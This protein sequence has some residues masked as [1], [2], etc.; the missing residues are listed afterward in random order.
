[1]E[2]VTVKGNK[3]VDGANREV[4]LQGI[5]FVCKEKNKGYLWPEH[6]R[7]FAWCAWMGFN[8]IRLGIFWDGVEPEPGKYD[9]AY[10]EKIKGVI[11]DAQEQGLYV[12]VDM[13]QD[14]WSVLYA[15][16][17]PEWA[18]LTD[19]A[20]H[21]TDCAIWF[22]A[23]LRSDAIINAADH[24]WKNDPAADGR[25]LMDHYEAMW[26][27]IAQTLGGCP[28]VIG[29]EPMNEPFMG[30]IARG[31]FGAAAMET[32]QKYP[33]FDLQKKADIAPESQEYF[34]ELVG[35]KFLDFDREI[36]MP[37]YERMNRAIRKYSDIP[38]ATGGNIY[39]GSSF[40]TGLERVRREDSKAEPLQ[41]YA[42]HGYDSVV[43]SDCYEN[44]SKEN[45]ARLFAGKRATQECLGMP[46]LVGEWGAFPSKDFTNELIEHMNGILEQYH[47]SSAYWQY[48]PGMETDAHFSALR[49]AYPAVTDGK[50]VRYH[51][52][53][54][55]GKL[56]VV[57]MG[58]SVLCYLPFAQYRIEADEADACLDSSLE[59]G[60]WVKLT[61]HA[62]E[63]E[64]MACIVREKAS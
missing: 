41:I 14:L 25:G 1:M 20:E 45:V 12:L 8:L 27:K 35:S 11:E 23:Y 4:L 59:G 5:N 36:L 48:L 15:D 64:I 32:K 24:F 39:C 22:E 46:V 31:A 26:E 10:L 16:G 33:E 51:Y 56:E 6:K 55:C 50:L 43:D 38:L 21:P 13:H 63:R 42:P 19:G 7:S 37:F 29:F 54:D 44:F 9:Q 61:S 30:S 57:W 2:R 52:D 3:F 28:N 62:P 60:A 49:R 18:T 40:P 47:W 34:I 17:A 53:R 58:E